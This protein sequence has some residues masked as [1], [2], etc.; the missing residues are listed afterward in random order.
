MASL[1][2]GSIDAAIEGT[3]RGRFLQELYSNS[4][5]LPIAIVLLEVL[6]EGGSDYFLKADFYAITLGA[7]VQ[8][9]F[10]SRTPDGER[11]RRL[12]GNLAGPAVYSA[13]E[14][15]TEGPGFFAA[16]H[17]KAY[18]AF[19]LAIGLLQCARAGRRT[20]AADILMVVENAVRSMFLF[21]IYYIFESLTAPP[22]GPARAFLADPSHAFIGWSILLLGLAGGIAA[23][24]EQ[25]YL[26]ML[27]TL[28]RRLRV[29]SEWLFGRALLEE[30]VSD[31]ER[32]SLKR[33]ERAILFMDV[34]GF[35]AWSEAQPPES[36]VAV[37]NGGCA[38]SES[39][40][41]RW[42]PI[43]CKFSADEVMGV[44]ARPG[45]ALG[46]ARCLARE[47]GDYLRPYG[48]GVGIGLHWGAVV[49]G[50]MGGT[51]AK[52]FDVIGD[53]VNTAK[54]IEGAAARGEILLSEDFRA[55]AGLA[56]AAS[57][58][59][60]VKGKSAPLVV[61]PALLDSDQAVS[62]RAAVP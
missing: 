5:V 14:V 47:V 33:R 10:L 7:L 43:R 18:W 44:F 50:L 36:V 60:E 54:R 55:A 57:R 21:A 45:D 12:L 34:R 40:F 61:H 58:T 1:R 42:S 30:A 19:A 9:G 27:R 4:A 51:G 31:P 28:S 24:G 38:A 8:A 22:T 16:P 35:T 23:V 29:Y 2:P 59:I 6:L 25:R 3:A 37:L 11:L 20:I 62:G 49:E 48:L 15:A 13:I 39:V 41:A 32:L 46:A 17:H 26:A 53:T 56:V 52:Q